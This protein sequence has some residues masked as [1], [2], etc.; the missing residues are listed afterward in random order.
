M[1]KF[2][3]RVVP[4][5]TK[6][7]KAAGAKTPEQRFAAAIE[8]ALNEEAGGGWEFQRAETLPSVERQGLT[9]SRTVFQNVLVF[10]RPRQAESDAPPA[11]PL[12]ITAQDPEPEAKPE[13]PE[14]SEPPRTQ[15]IFR[16][17]PK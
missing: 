16:T 7:Q 1:S 3:Y 4:A 17:R 12:A 8:A 13:Q 5:P 9:G 15:N 10:R 2:E 11:P 6:G 14:P